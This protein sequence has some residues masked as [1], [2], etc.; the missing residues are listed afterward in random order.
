MAVEVV[1]TL[2]TATETEVVRESTVWNDTGA[3]AP[4]ADA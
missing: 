1:T 2:T 4:R 3:A